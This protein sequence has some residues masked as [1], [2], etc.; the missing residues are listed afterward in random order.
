MLVE[1]IF[2]L[3]TF[4]N[5]SITYAE[6]CAELHVSI[7]PPSKQLIDPNMLTYAKDVF[8]TQAK[9]DES[10]ENK[11]CTS[12]L[13]ERDVIFELFTPKNP[14][15]PQILKLND[16]ST[17]K[18]S[19]FIRKFPTRMLIHG[20][21][22]RGQLTKKF[23]AAYFIKGAHKVNFI[24]VNWRK[25]SNDFNYFC[26][27]Q[28]VNE[29]GAYVARFIDF[30]A[31]Q[32]WVNVGALTI[33]GHSL[34]AHISGLSAKKANR[35]VGKIVGLDPALPTFKYEEAENRLADTDASYVE[36]I[37]TCSGKLGHIE[38]LA[39]ANFYPNGGVVQ[40][41]CI[42]DVLGIFAHS[43]AWEF[44][45]ESINRPEFY[46][47][48]CDSL[49]NLRKGT[50]SVVNKIVKMGGEPGNRN[51]KGIFYLD[52]NDQSFFAKG[53][54]GLYKALETV[55]AKISWQSAL[56]KIPN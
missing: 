6:S 27:R 52:T 7:P 54:Q 50:C 1:L 21:Q 16:V 56:R 55:K 2:C 53:R 5:F 35:K 23:T 47:F 31:N 34:G 41:G 43:R 44:Y 48:E 17:A 12:F 3:V 14:T 18:A 45:V 40:P 42:M 37:Y 25:G 38:P 36:A 26:S 22:C 39:N 51:L 8:K 19:N 20:W 30:L 29:V 28:R 49:E 24:A 13:A 15:E 33:I 11:T 10:T 9:N 32:L 46:A 4:V